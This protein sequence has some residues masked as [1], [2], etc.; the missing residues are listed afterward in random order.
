MDDFELEL[1]QT[2][3]ED[4]TMIPVSDTYRA[5]TIRCLCDEMYGMCMPDQARK[6]AENVEFRVFKKRG[7]STTE[8]DAVIGEKIKSLNRKAKRNV[9]GCT[10]R[11]EGGG[12]DAMMMNVGIDNEDV[13]VRENANLYYYTIDTRVCK[14]VAYMD[15]DFPLGD[16]QGHFVVLHE[17][18]GALV[19]GQRR[20]DRMHFGIGVR[21][22]DDEAVRFRIFRS[23]S[24]T[25]PDV[26]LL[27]RRF[28]KDLVGR[29]RLG[30]AT[31]YDLLIIPC[32]HVYSAITQSTIMKV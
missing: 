18:T 24:E 19:K 32:V 30:Y 6:H 23:V 15:L 21:R 14:D 20:C 25:H 26:A 1:E 12:K 11:L 27:P 4:A 7:S 3:T 13:Y 2:L 9:V 5:Y 10:A 28:C 8:Y 17:E 22:L 31:E 16:F 29:M